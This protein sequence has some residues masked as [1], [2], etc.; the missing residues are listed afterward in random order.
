MI[1]T[2]NKL[3]N[4]SLHNI[5]DS[6]PNNGLVSPNTTYGIDVSSS[7]QRLDINNCTSVNDSSSP[8]NGL[9]SLIVN[10]GTNVYALNHG[11]ITLS[12]N[13]SILHKQDV[14]LRILDHGFPIA[15][16]D[17]LNHGFSTLSNSDSILHKHKRFH[18]I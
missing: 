3:G 18:Y 12:N 1:N 11:F 15:Y 14:F 10:E 9:V 16:K 6:S 13:D 17:A 5:N 4:R 2:R 7:N 8:N